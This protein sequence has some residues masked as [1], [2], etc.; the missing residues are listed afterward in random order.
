M[1]EVINHEHRHNIVDLENALL[2][3]EQIELPLRHTFANGVY[4]REMTIPA[5]VTL[6]GKIHRYPCINIISKGSLVAVTD[7]GTYQVEAPYTFV[8]GAGVKKAIHALTDSVW[9]TVHPWVGEEDLD[10]IEEKLIVPS[11][12]ALEHEQRLGIEGG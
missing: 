1:S 9:T 3:E 5:G 7:E 10:L 2:A 11:Y 4:A 6:T 8:S 12:E